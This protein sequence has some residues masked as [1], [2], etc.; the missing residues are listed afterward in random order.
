MLISAV[1]KISSVLPHL[2]YLQYYKIR[3]LCITELW[4]HGVIL[5][6]YLREKCHILCRR[7][8]EIFEMEEYFPFTFST[9]FRK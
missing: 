9:L 1:P 7:L 3:K 5:Q 2:S 6:T 4:Q 8:R